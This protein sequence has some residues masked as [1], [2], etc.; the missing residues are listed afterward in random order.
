MPIFT[1][2]QWKVIGL[3]VYVLFMNS[4][5]YF[6]SNSY[7]S[8][9][10][11]NFI[12]LRF[13]AWTSALGITST[14][15]LV[16]IL[17]FTGLATPSSPGSVLDPAPTDL[18]PAQGFVKLGLSFG[19]LISGFGGHFLIPNLIRDMKRP[20]QADRVCEVAYGICIV[21]YALVSVFGYLMF[22]RD[23][24]DEVSWMLAS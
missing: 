5:H 7:H 8:I 23:V 22:G 11:F 18:W 9:V 6:F 17:I 13:L 10:P 16:A 2:N 4:E 19:L 1:S 3:L 15:T 12:P 20:E 14:W 24:S 21:V